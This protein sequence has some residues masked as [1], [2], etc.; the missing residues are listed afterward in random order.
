MSL[1]SSKPSM[2]ASYSSWLF[3]ALKSKRSDCFMQRLLNPSRTTPA[4]PPPLLEDP[5]TYRIH[6][7]FGSKLSCNYE[8]KSARLCDFID[9]LGSYLITNS[10]NSIDHLI[11]QP[12]NSGFLNTLLI[13]QSVRTM[14]S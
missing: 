9:P 12:A 7:T 5:S 1:A 4:P 11:I 3:D 10:D 8:V 14:I 13:G 2:S 6:V